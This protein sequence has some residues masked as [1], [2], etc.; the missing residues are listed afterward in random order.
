MARSG[1]D[2]AISRQNLRMVNGKPLIY[3]IIKTALKFKNASVVV[4]SDSE[5]IKE[6]SKMYGAQV[7]H[8]PKKLTTN[9][10]SIKEICLD[11][12]KKIKYNEQNLE[13]CLVLHPKIPLIKLKT[14]NTFFKMSK[15]NR[16]T[17][18]GISN[19]I[20]AKYAYKINSYDKFFKLKS[21]PYQ[22]GLLNKIVCFKIKS[23]VENN[24]KFDLPFCG[25]NLSKSETLALKTYSEFGIFE[26]I[27]SKRKILVRIDG[28]KSIGMGHVYNILSILNHFRNDEIL[29]VM[30][31]KTSLGSKKFR[32][33]LYDVKLFSSFT[34]LEKII[35]KFKPDIIFNDVLN[36]K[37][38]YMRKL[39][40]HCCFIV[41]FEDLGDGRKFANL[42]FNPIFKTK[43]ILPNEF[44][45]G[46][47]ACV[48]DE[49]RLFKNS[50]LQKIPKK[51]VISYGG[52]DQN[53][54]TEKTIDI[55]KKHN[56]KNIEFTVILGY[57]F[58]TISKIKENISNLNNDGFR[59]NLIIN[60]D[61]LAKHVR[62]A[63]FSIISNGRT[64][65]EFAAMCV[66]LISVSVNSRE[67]SHS[68]VM[69]E[70]I[71]FHF[72]YE[73][74][75]FEKLIIQGINK[76]LLYRNRKLFKNRLEKLDLLQGIDNVVSII[77][78]K[79]DQQFNLKKPN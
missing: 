59:F 60:S 23:F 13:Y 55:I 24:G 50:I 61:F 73:D 7:I 69:D 35:E 14:I 49:F 11:A 46:K 22:I 3:Y 4:S 37:E 58:T 25:I 62:D 57:G 72:N 79:Y 63:D 5:E 30:H 31:K 71:G 54:L 39:G 19:I 53:N 20:D 18:F 67:K 38:D 64:V 75:S 12:L 15:A 47:Y 44:Y 48:R 27:L 2:D 26:Q 29:V 34:E 32:E 74:S 17:F 65:F 68:F 77:N 16:G 33:H 76:M 41:N 52:T 43:K 78:S 45:G 1:S 21:N 40:T 36:T 42:V 66:P 6:L 56:I 28:S 70:K 51:V 8:R 10:T 9:R